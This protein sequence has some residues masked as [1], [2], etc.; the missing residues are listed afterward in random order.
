MVICGLAWFVFILTTASFPSVPRFPSRG[1]ALGGEALTAQGGCARA[2]PV[3]NLPASERPGGR[4]SRHTA[5]CHRHRAHKEPVSGLRKA[6]RYSAFG[7]M[8]LWRGAPPRSALGAPRGRSRSGVSAPAC[9]PRPAAPAS[10]RPSPAAV[11]RV[12]SEAPAQPPRGVRESRNKSPPPPAA[13][14][15]TVPQGQQKVRG[16]PV[17]L[18]EEGARTEEQQGGHAED[19][20]AQRKEREQR[21][22][23]PP[24]KAPALARAPS[25]RRRRGEP[26]RRA[27]PA[28][29][30]LLVH[31]PLRRR[32][33]TQPAGGSASSIRLPG[34]GC[35]RPGKFPGAQGIRSVPIAGCPWL[36]DKRESPALLQRR[37]LLLR[38]AAK[39]RRRRWS[40]S[41]SL[42]LFSSSA[43]A[44]APSLRSASRPG[45]KLQP[46]LHR[47][48]SV[49]RGRLM[50]AARHPPPGPARPGPGSR[51]GPGARP[52]RPT[53]ARPGP[54]PAMHPPPPRQ[55]PL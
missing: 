47:R 5:L 8:N 14:T 22:G 18:V 4:R 35:L 46:E 12:R 9:P 15:Q 33:L 17:E 55:R 30:L 34:S 16:S 36:R 28:A 3:R 10:G 37:L 27:F 20:V 26:G 25:R 24:R 54:G 39:G 7:S 49:T 53:P 29:G 41:R 19:V 31:P 51:P 45:V 44:L 38:S 21:E 52:P 40:P 6:R 23:P 50:R 11:S 2:P 13:L 43:A 32:R 42:G 1:T 48:P